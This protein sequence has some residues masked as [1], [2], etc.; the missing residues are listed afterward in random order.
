MSGQQLLKDFREFNLV[1][2]ISGGLVC[3][4][5]SGVNK[6]AFFYHV[7]IQSVNFICIV[8]KVRPL[9]ASWYSWCGKIKNNT[10]KFVL[11]GWI[12]C[13]R[14][15]ELIMCVYSLFQAFALF[16]MLYAFFWVIPRRLEFKCR[17]F[18]TLFHLHRQVDVSRMK[19]GIR[20]DTGKGLA[21]S[22]MNH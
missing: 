12:K 6:T 4:C 16:Y 10:F 1:F 19:L 17:R 3:Y 15:T 18:G 9:N 5:C 14:S 21:R 2:V 22:S 13:V 8:R 7:Y 20:N 11:H